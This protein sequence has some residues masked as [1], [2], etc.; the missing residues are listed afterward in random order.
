MN[1]RVEVLIVGGGP[2][3]PFLGSLLIQSGISCMILEQRTLATSH[4]RSIGIHPPALERL[5]KIGVVDEILSRGIQVSGGVAFVNGHKIGELSFKHCRPPFPFIVSLPQCE[6]EAILEARLLELDA[7]TLRRGV[8]VVRMEKSE[9]GV[10]VTALKNEVELCFEADYVVGC[11]GLNSVVRNLADIP[12]KGGTYPDTYV[13]GDFTDTT[14]L[15]NQAGI[16]L[17]RHGVVES[18]PLPGGLRRWVVKTDSQLE[19][20]EAALL[21]SLVSRRT[22]IEPDDSTC[23]MISSFSVSHFFADS[24]SKGRIILAGD[25]AHI[26][27]PIG[28]QGMNLGWLDAFSLFEAFSLLKKEGWK[29]SAGLSDVF[30]TYSSKR[31]ASAT[32]AR[33]RSEL[34]MWLGRG[35]KFGVLQQMVARVIFMPFL[36][37]RFANQ[38]T[39]RGLE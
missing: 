21:R 4:S 13:M 35:S 31:L 27:S 25:A 12:F 38:F 8:R 32:T 16:F 6:T 2:T 18:F 28:G 17:G 5:S 14:H 10:S 29:N 20:P 24:M 3:G 7:S 26:V 22:G 1:P 19:N 23:S 37:R 34:N 33:K 11:D 36:R 15:G 9:K 30:A 39:M